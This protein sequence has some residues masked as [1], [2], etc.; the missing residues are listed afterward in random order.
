[1]RSLRVI[2]GTVL[3]TLPALAQAETLVP[4]MGAQ[5]P[6]WVGPTVLLVFLA[7]LALVL[8]EEF[9][10]LSKSKPMVAA[11][12]IIW[13]LIAAT[14]PDTG[15]AAVIEAVRGHLT[16]YTEI[17]LFLLVMLMYAKTLDE[18]QVYSH[19]RYRIACYGGSYRQRYWLASGSAF[20]LAPILG[21]ITTVIFLGVLVLHDA[22]ER[23]RFVALT[24]VAIVVAANAGGMVTPFGDITTLMLWQQAH[25]IHVTAI[26]VSD[27]F[28]LLPA[29]LVAFLI[30]AWWIS[31]HLPQGTLTAPYEPVPMLRGGPTTLVLLLVTLGLTVIYR[32]LLHLPASIGMLTGFS[33]LQFYGFYLKRTHTDRH[34]DSATPFD[35]FNLFHRVEWDTL[36]FL[37]GTTLSIGGLGYLGYLSGLSVTLFSD[38]GGMAASLWM[39]LG[40]G[41]LGGATT[42]LT[43]LE[44][45][46]PLD[47][48]AWLGNGLTI[49]L[50]SAL[51]PIGSMA[52]IALL[53]LLQGR[54]TV[55]GH[56]RWSPAIAV[57]MLAGAL[58]HQLMA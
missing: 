30:P 31:R 57:G 6:N 42:M 16:E 5:F 23:D 43:L 20:L 50:G 44:M 28:S 48:H 40:A 8:A 11:A 7:A 55:L 52:G 15:Q 33:L 39:G 49:A 18:R 26:H 22:R 45:N 37:Y 10:G 27:L 47:L 19:L 21:T 17:M 35:I 46:P 36:L 38:F 25:P 2:C 13:I 32:D 34:F 58:L 51:L 56:L 29:A 24:A 41:V 14:A 12:G 3:A 1:M 4:A 53:G 9:I 54:Y